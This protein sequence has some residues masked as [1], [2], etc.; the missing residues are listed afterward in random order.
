MKANFCLRT[1]LFA[2][3]LSAIPAIALSQHVQQLQLIH[4]IAPES[5]APQK[6]ALDPCWDS[7]LLVGMTVGVTGQ[8]RNVSETVP[9]QNVHVDFSVGPELAFKAGATASQGTWNYT[10]GSQSATL[11]AIGTIPPGGTVTY[12]FELDV[13]A[14]GSDILGHIIFVQGVPVQ[15][16]GCTYEVQAASPD[17]TVEKTASHPTYKVGEQFSYVVTIQND[18]NGSANSILLVD[19]LPETVE[20]VS[21]PT[22]LWSNCT[23]SAANNEIQCTKDTLPAGEGINLIIN[24]RA[25]APGI[26]DNSVVVS[27]S[28][29]S[30]VIDRAEVEIMAPSPQVTLNKTVEQ[31]DD[32]QQIIIGNQ[33][34]YKIEVENTGDADAT[35]LF[36]HD[37]LPDN[38]V[39][40]TL[41]GGSDGWSCSY[42][43]LD[44]ELSCL[45]AILPAGSKTTLRIL[46]EA[47]FHGDASNT[48]TLSGENFGELTSTATAT[49][50]EL[51]PS[52]E[53]HKK[54]IGVENHLDIPI[55][56]KFTYFIT[57]SNNGEGTAS[58]VV[59]V[60]PLPDGLVFL[61]L[62]PERWQCDFDN[63]TRTINCSIASLLSDADVVVLI[64][65]EAATVGNITNIAT[66]QGS[67]FGVVTMSAEATIT[68]LS[69]VIVAEK[70][71]TGVDNPLDIPVGATFPYSINVTNTGEG[72]AFGLT[73]EDIIPNGL[74]LE[75]IEMGKWQCTYDIDSNSIDC[76]LDTLP[77]GESAPVKVVVKAAS[78][79]F[80]TNIVRVFGTNFTE[81]TATAEAIITEQ[82]PELAAQKSTGEGIDPLNIKLG[83]QFT[84]EITIANTGGGAANSLVVVDILPETVTHIQTDAARSSCSFA[85]TS[86]TLTCTLSILEPG[87]IESIIVHVNAS[88]PGVADNEAVIA[89]EGVAELVAKV[90][91]VIVEPVNLSNVSGLKF[92][93][94]N[95]NGIQDGFDV[96]FNGVTIELLNAAGIVIDQDVT[97]SVDLN[98]DGLIDPFTEQGLFFFKNLH[99]GSYTLREIVPPN[100]VQTVPGGF[101]IYDFTV[102]NE[103][104]ELLFVF[105]NMPLVGDMD[106]GDL[107][108]P[109]TDIPSPGCPP[110]RVC[111]Q[112]TLAANGASH[113][114]TG[115]VWLGLTVDAEPDGQPS[116]L[117]DG[118]DRID[119]LTGD[120][121]DE[122][123]LYSAAV[124][125]D[126]S[127]QI[128]LYATVMPPLADAVVQIWIDLD[129][130][131]TFDFEQVINERVVNGLN[132]LTTSPGLKQPN[133]AIG[134]MRLR[135]S[136]F[137]GLASFGLAPDGEVEDYYILGMDFGDAPESKDPNL[138]IPGGY[139]TN[140]AQNGA[141]HIVNNQVRL[142]DLIDAEGAAK[143]DIYAEGDDR[144]NQNDEDGIL[145]QGGFTMVTLPDVVYGGTMQ[146]Y[147]VRRNSS[148]TFT[149]LA[150][151][152]GRLSVW[153]DWN[154][155]G[156]WEDPGELV[157]DDIL[158][159]GPPDY[160]QV[161]FQVPHGAQPGLTFARF[162][163]SR[164]G[165]LNFDGPAPDGE[166]EDYMIHISSAS[167]VGLIEETADNPAT[168]TLH[169][170]YPNPFNPTT[171]IP[172]EI[173]KASDV[174]LSVYTID[175]RLIRTIVNQ[176]LAAGH[177]S[178]QFDGSGLGSGIY[179]YILRAGD[180][181]FI[182]KFVLVK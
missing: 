21:V 165:G 39:Y 144:D 125:P 173:A 63:P 62:I 65:V 59:M 97:H 84:Y 163:F 37:V 91:V 169:P 143:S 154:R 78:P 12:G 131:G 36:I 141:R 157:V 41:E 94:L 92:I 27:G 99:P 8:I 23:F 103:I 166:V 117:A 42:L 121:D 95:G 162:R 137:G 40:L 50:L 45:R 2:L 73:L 116:P 87:A 67:N 66:V 155:D 90:E 147:E 80:V 101:G 71:V 47:D 13:I 118:D 82:L 11:N 75:D 17:I 51:L 105:G 28:N 61:D 16:R 81:T 26:A 38:V 122:D 132:T 111:Y 22:G 76:A 53:A 170:N 108:Q 60:D 32:P 44:R 14:T 129:N 113:L 123:G 31:V 9:L 34:V 57:V 134:Y 142:G 167:P 174:E 152:Q 4:Q 29:F 135:I 148:A 181:I 158:V 48:V 96:G 19:F 69:P 106:F 93:D 140:L 110:G 109:R 133:E 178:F 127:I 46:V 126:G 177:Y 52:I 156:D 24:V 83:S 171:Q 1:C 153:I 146:R 18:G 151:I 149:P 128:V 49:I 120:I 77:P 54:I 136:T 3:L 15:S 43:E 124:M 161:T 55:G 112:T 72:A 145:F 150:N 5:Q 182:R 164:L 20:L 114:L 7:P 104:S 6:P 119:P 88:A 172:F 58:N 68:E 74:T 175:G 115:D 179:L 138:T 30:E 168:T 33:F 89:A 139:P 160:T 64:L 98:G 102:A 86:A 85:T 10:A 35:D 107:P 79:G 176:S 100:F 70:S 25:I 180:Q 130:D 159:N 56:T